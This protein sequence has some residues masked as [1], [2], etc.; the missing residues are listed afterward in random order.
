MDP[1]RGYQML[2]SLILIRFQSYE[3][4][5]LVIAFPAF[6]QRSVEDNSGVSRT[7]LHNKCRI[8]ILRKLGKREGFRLRT[9]FK[10]LQMRSLKT[11]RFYGKEVFGRSS[12]SFSA[13]VYEFT[14]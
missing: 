12:T 10:Y 2:W 3:S 1:S 14:L 13:N 6:S 5:P 8:S 7:C 4:I 9:N 11:G